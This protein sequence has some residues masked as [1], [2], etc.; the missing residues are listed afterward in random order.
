[1]LKMKL[2]IKKNLPRCNSGFKLIQIE[3]A[4]VLVAPLKPRFD[5]GELNLLIDVWTSNYSIRFIFR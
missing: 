1:M 2:R 5:V 4:D 3:T